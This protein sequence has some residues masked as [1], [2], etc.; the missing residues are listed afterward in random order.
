MKLKSIIITVIV[1]IGLIILKF[2]CFPSNINS[3]K[4]Y[5]SKNGKQSLTNV[6]AIITKSEKLENTI[7]SSGTIL[8]NEEIEL[9]PEI[10][11]KIIQLN[12]RE[13]SQVVKGQLLVKI[14][15]TEFQ[16]QL[17]KLIIQKKLAETQLNRELELLKIKGISQQ[18]VDISANK[19]SE[20][21]ADIEFVQAQIEKTEIRAAF[22]GIIGLKNV[23][24]GAFVTN[25]T[26][27][28]TIQQINPVKLDFSV[29][30][31]YSE[32]IRKGNKVEF[33]IEGFE[34]NFYGEIAAIEPKI[35]LNTRTL[36]VRATCPNSGNKIYPGAFA[37]VKIELGSIE[38]A[39]MV[40][41]ESIIPVLKGKTVFVVKN[42][43]AEIVQVETGNRTDKMVQII[44]GLKEG[45]TVIK[46]GIMQIKPG[47]SVKITNIN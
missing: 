13:G 16:A 30:E 21:N 18:E 44:K 10:A 6:T 17:K 12:I 2:K 1:I 41:T 25:T 9:K 24:D 36:K 26:V 20:L 7:F 46:T 27:I 4:S 42:G 47:M 15:D 29:S 8:A 3:N 40:P 22:N 33:N 39:I 43:M 32:S 31:K 34:N 11:G 38:N 19:V 14:K 23:S 35:D 37:N 28:A 5:S 45:D